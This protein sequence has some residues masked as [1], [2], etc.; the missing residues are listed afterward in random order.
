MRFVTL[1]ELEDFRIY[2]RD[3]EYHL[4]ITDPKTTKLEA[5]KNTGNKITKFIDQEAAK[6][7]VAL[8]DG[9]TTDGLS[10][11]E[12]AR[13]SYE[14]EIANSKIPELQIMDN[15]FLN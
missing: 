13:T 12:W 6:M 1:K 7:T 3:R 11:L 4:K 15:Y 2:A 9:S 14:I 10:Y 8:P 5:W